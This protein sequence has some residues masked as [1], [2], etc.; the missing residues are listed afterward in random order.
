MGICLEFYHKMVKSPA[1]NL[2]IFTCQ[3]SQDSRKK[4]DLLNS[5]L[6]IQSRSGHLQ[7]SWRISDVGALL[8]TNS[9]AI[10]IWKSKH[11][12]NKLR[13]ITRML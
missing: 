12:A 6:N 2:I 7:L 10:T 3:N 1:V 13:K 9:I 5:E 4:N 8:T 11:I